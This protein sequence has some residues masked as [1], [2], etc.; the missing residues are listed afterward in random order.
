M[1]K[2]KKGKGGKKKRRGKKGIDV[3]KRRLEFKEEGQEYARVLKML[4]DGRIET[5]CS[6][7]KVRVCHIRGKMRKRVW[8]NPGDLI[9]VDIRQYQQDK[10]DVVYK[11]NEDEDRTLQSYGELTDGTA[12]EDQEKNEDKV[13]RFNDSL[14]DEDIW[15]NP[16]T[17]KEST[18][19]ES[20]ESEEKSK[21]LDALLQEL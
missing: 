1:P 8:I 10:A 14:D 11:Y 20:T 18:E 19:K 15:Q 3:E 13:I 7:G 5:R 4:G 12:K 21:D 9:L 16:S 2:G 6:D 17:E